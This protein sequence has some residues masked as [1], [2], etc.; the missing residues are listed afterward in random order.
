MANSYYYLVS[1]LADITI[2]DNKLLFSQTSF[3]DDIR[4]KIA[5]R[6]YILV[7][8]LFL[9]Y[10]NENL[11]SLLKDEDTFNNKGNYTKDFIDSAIR[12]DSGLP[13]Y[14]R[15][16]IHL[17]RNADFKYD[18]ISWEVQLASLY[19]E[20]VL[21]LDNDFLKRWFLFE[22]SLNNIISALN[23]RKHGYNPKKELVYVEGNVIYDS[24]IN[25][26]NT[27]DFDISRHFPFM[28]KLINLHEH[29]YLLERERKV[30]LYKWQTLDELGLFY[31][32]TIE[33]IL[34]YILKLRIVERWLQLDILFAKKVFNSLFKTLEKDSESLYTY[35]GKG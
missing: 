22:L 5:L 35:V 28:D 20:H 21:S 2:N 4:D 33:R 25:K 32:F 24:I 14:M 7:E 26:Y 19:Y 17:F 27:R 16:F 18:G 31:Y 29:S 15:T 13:D 3:R 1:G 11:I 10:D 23:C 12:Y 30:D 8:S 6:D 34:I 9:V